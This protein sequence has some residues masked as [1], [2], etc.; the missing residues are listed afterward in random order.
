M[1]VLEQNQV[2]DAEW[3]RR[4]D[5]TLDAHFERLERG[6]TKFDE[7]DRKIAENTKIT[8]NTSNDVK[9]LLAIFKPLTGF[10]TVTGWM[11]KGLVWVAAIVI[12]A[13][14]IFWYVKTGD[15][16]RKP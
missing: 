15:L 8:T 7:L 14:V 12:A 3:R 11:G 4:V 6:D 16:P 1:G 10:F 13:G 5:N 9:E 2:A